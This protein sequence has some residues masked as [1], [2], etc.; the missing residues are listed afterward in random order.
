MAWWIFVVAGLFFV[1]LETLL[2]LDFF[3]FFMGV[4]AILTG[5]LEACGIFD[6]LSHLGFTPL[7]VQLFTYVVLLCISYFG[8]KKPIVKMFSRGSEEY[9]DGLAGM[10]VKI[11]DD[12]EAGAEGRAEARGTT[13]EVRNQT[14]G[15]LSAGS[16]VTVS[17][18]DGK[19]LVIK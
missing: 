14:A 8:C 16:E 1:F 17:E 18:A 4:A 5:L 7:T 10:K 15:K 3:F 12:I 9:N 19:M 13:W 11:L 6:M 2:P